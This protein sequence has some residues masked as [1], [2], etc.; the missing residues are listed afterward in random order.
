M[1]GEGRMRVWL[2]LLVLIGVA[3]FYNLGGNRLDEQMVRD[4]Y[5]RS[6]QALLAQ[7]AEALC[8]ML[9]EDFQQTITLRVESQEKRETVDKPKY[10]RDLA[11][12]MEQVRR[13]QAAMGGRSPIEYRQTVV[14]VTL[15]PD[16]RSAEVEMRS[17]LAMP[18]VRM[19]SRNR[20]TVVRQRWKMLATHSEG[21]TW[22][23]PA[24]R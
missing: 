23:G 10:C 15:A 24:Y 13:L 17:T 18:G 8:A 20:D 22:M 19:T 16:K 4:F 9:A 1:T 21:T 12:S 7:D 11:A 6:E 2:L 5:Q 14:S 3:L